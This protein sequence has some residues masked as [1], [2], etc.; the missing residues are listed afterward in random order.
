ME[1]RSN[2]YK[3]RAANQFSLSNARFRTVFF[4]FFIFSRPL[5]LRLQLRFWCEDRE[6]RN[7]WNECFSVG[8]KWWIRKNPR[9]R[10]KIVPPR[11]S[12]CSGSKISRRRDGVEEGREVSCPTSRQKNEKKKKNRCTLRWIKWSMSDCS[13]LLSKKLLEIGII[14]CLA[15]TLDNWNFWGLRLA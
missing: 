5:I 3:S 15:Y 13:L 1:S 11:I 12:R 2:C 8:G 6:K 10:K 14:Y 7:E 9:M 4:L